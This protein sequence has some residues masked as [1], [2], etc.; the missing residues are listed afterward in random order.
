[1]SYNVDNKLYHNRNIVEMEDKI[2]KFSLFF[3]INL[4]S[5]RGKKYGNM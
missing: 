3:D 5:D 4:V 2:L 1:M